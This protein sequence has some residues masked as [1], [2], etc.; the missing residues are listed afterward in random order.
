MILHIVYWA[1]LAT[2]GL[3]NLW[4]VRQNYHRSFTIGGSLFTSSLYDKYSFLLNSINYFLWAL[5]VVV[6][7]YW[8]VYWWLT[9]IIF[10]ISYIDGRKKALKRE[11]QALKEMELREDLKDINGNPRTAEEE[12]VRLLEFR[13][14]KLSGYYNH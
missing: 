8:D 5:T 11:Y 9:P 3:L 2:L 1:I 6:G 13:K 4:L 7:F 10:Y 14:K 12:F